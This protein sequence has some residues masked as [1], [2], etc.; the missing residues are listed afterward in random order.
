VTTFSV[1]KPSLRDI[2]IRIAGHEAAE[3]PDA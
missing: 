3:A 1:T 2:F